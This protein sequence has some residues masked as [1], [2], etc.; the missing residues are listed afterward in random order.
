L[1]LES[2]GFSKFECFGGFAGIGFRLGDVGVL[3]GLGVEVG[4]AGF[5]FLG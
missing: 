2:G 3:F 1:V 5:R 4:E